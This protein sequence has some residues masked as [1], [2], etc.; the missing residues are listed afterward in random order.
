[1]SKREYPPQ[2]LLDDF[3]AWYDDLSYG[4]QADVDTIPD[5]IDLLPEFCREWTVAELW[6]AIRDY[7]GA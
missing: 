7:I 4:K 1:M 5:D 6:T 3:T 2:D